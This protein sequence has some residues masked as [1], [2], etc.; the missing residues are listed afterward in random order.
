MCTKGASAAG[1][2]GTTV[3]CPWKWSSLSPNQAVLLVQRE[4][5]VH[6]PLAPLGCF[7]VLLS[8]ASPR[9]LSY[10]LQVGVSEIPQL[11]GLPNLPI[12]QAQADGPGVFKHQCTPGL[13][14]VGRRGRG[15][16]WPARQGLC[17]L[18]AVPSRGCSRPIKQGSEVLR[19]R[20]PIPQ[21]GKPRLRE[22][23]G[24]ES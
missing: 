23:L 1:P 5:W 15:A 8:W 4:E 17:C 13:H 21:L 16:S 24:Q 14:P 2:V 6:A 11:E 7:G 12:L 19:P 3:C 10:Q 22:A 20:S 18:R 9:A